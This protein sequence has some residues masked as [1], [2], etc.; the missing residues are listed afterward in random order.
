MPPE[1]PNA[2]ARRAQVDPPLTEAALY[3]AALGLAGRTLGEL[4]AG[5]GFRLPA[6][7]RRRKGAVGELLERVL[8]ATAN[9]RPVPDFEHLGIELKTVPIDARERPRESTHVCTV[10]LRELVGERWVTSTV[11]AKLRR[12]LWIPIETRAG[13]A[14]DARR[15]GLARLWSPSAAEEDVLRRDWE[16]HLELLATGRLEQ[17]DARMGTYLQ[18]RPKA[19]NRRALGAS[20]NREGEPAATL[21]RGFYLRARFTATIL[22]AGGAR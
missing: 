4:A 16:E 15:V 20:S 9:S 6:D 21:P 10:A 22:A 3:T 7:L 8:G 5:A 1:Q 11:R 14:L 18:V 17:L 12:V 2:V 19:P 13:L